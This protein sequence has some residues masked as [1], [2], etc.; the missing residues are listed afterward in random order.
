MTTREIATQKT[1]LGPVSTAVLAT[2]LWVSP[3]PAFPPWDESFQVTP[4]SSATLTIR[5][6]DGSAPP[7]PT[8][9][10]VSTLADPEIKPSA[11]PGPESTGPGDEPI[12]PEATPSEVDSGFDEFEA[13]FSTPGDARV[14][15]PLSGYNRIMTGFNDWMYFWVLSPVAKGYNFVVPEPVRRS[16]NR[17]FNNLLF[18]VRFVN[19]VL[20]LK[21]K[22]AGVELTR[23]TLNTTIGIAGFFDPAKAWLDLDPYPE[24]FGQTL[25]HWG[26]GGGFHIVLPFLGPSNLRDSIS[27]LP[28]Y[29]ADPVCYLGTCYF[30]YWEAALGVKSFDYVNRNSLRLGEY[31]SLKKDAVDLYTFLRDAYEQKRRKEIEQ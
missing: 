21:A 13:E 5:I 27:L 12:P 4:P 19:N 3:A 26:L 30:G 1:I 6:A 24:D 2:F 29:V 7:P 28:D 23:F 18:P 20:Q 10:Q 9:L 25:G 31:E 22:G 8:A 15:D 11:E 17:F 14:F 16:I